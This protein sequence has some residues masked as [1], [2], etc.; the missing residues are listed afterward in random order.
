MADEQVVLTEQE[1]TDLREFLASGQ[2]QL[3]RIPMAYGQQELIA[4]AMGRV[5]KLSVEEVKRLIASWVNN[6]SINE[7]IQVLAR[8][9]TNII[10]G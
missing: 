6:K 10:I 7:Q 4:E 5:G 8:Q 9:R 2:Y 1:K 3:D